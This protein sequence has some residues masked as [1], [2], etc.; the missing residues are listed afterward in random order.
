MFDVNKCRSYDLLGNLTALIDPQT[1]LTLSYDALSRLTAANDPDYTQSWSYDRNG[2]RLSQWHHGELTGYGIDPASNRLLQAGSRAYQYDANGNLINDGKHSYHY[3][4]RNRLTAV[5]NGQTARYTHN[6]LGQRIHNPNFVQ[7]IRNAVYQALTDFYQDW[8]DK[9]AAQASARQQNA[10]ALS[11]QAQAKT[12]EAAQLQQQADNLSQQAEAK[13]QE[14]QQLRAE[15]N[16]HLQQANQLEQQAAECRALAEQG[17]T[18]PTT[19][20]TTVFNYDEHGQLI[21]EYDEAGNA[22]QETVWLGN[23]PV[24]TV[25]NGNTYA[26]HA[27]HLG[28]PRVI[29]NSS[30][31]E[32]W[33][34]DSDPFG[35]TAANEDPDDDGNR[36]VFNL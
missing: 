31:T 15:A 16:D 10:D 7:R 9:R 21:G 29:T 14:A 20:Q 32:V 17:G 30:Y 35:T 33:R 23:L 5:N 4:A 13:Q 22:R 25:Q 1:H 34:W 27:D 6:A 18:A 36:L 24:A 3:D 26:V 12:E 19:S 8:S 2:N 28:T 11:Q